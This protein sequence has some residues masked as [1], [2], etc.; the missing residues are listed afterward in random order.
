MN[1]QMFDL[2]REFLNLFQECHLQHLEMTLLPRIKES[3]WLLQYEVVI[4]LHTFRLVAEALTK[5]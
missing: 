2:V 4:Q 1:C 3:A 5:S